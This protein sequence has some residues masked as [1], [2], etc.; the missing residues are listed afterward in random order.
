MKFILTLTVL[1]SS[2]FVM[3]E[4]ITATKTT[5]R[6]INPDR[7]EHP[8][9]RPPLNRPIV[10]PAIVAPVVVYE[11]NYY[12]NNTANSCEQ[13]ITQIEE[14]NRDI[15]SL[16]VEIERLKEIEAKH[17]Q[18]SLKTQ[19]EKEMLEFDNRQNSVKSKNSINIT[20]KP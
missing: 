16:K 12:T 9:V 20:N 10:R 8:I 14:M 19:H 15:V 5:P 17:L 3:A 7:P 1:I 2:L 6:Y 4:P 13:Y 11:D 18:K